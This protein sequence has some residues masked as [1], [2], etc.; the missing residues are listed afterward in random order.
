MAKKKIRKRKPSVTKKTRKANVRKRKSQAK[1]KG[2]SYIASKLH[3]YWKATYPTTKSA[4]PKAHEV[5][6]QLKEKGLKVSVANIQ[7]V[8]R[9]H[10]TPKTPDVAPFIPPEMFEQYAFYEV[11]EGEYPRWISETSK[12]IEFRS[13]ITP[14]DISVFPGGSNVEYSTHFK[15]FADYCN[16]IFKLMREKEDVPKSED[17]CL[18]ST[19]EPKKDKKGQWYVEIYTCDVH[20]EEQDYGFDNENPSLEPIEI[21]T[22][23]TELE[24]GIRK[25]PTPPPATPPTTLPTEPQKTPTTPGIEI[26]RLKSDERVAIEKIKADVSVREAKIKSIEGMFEKNKITFEQYMDAL[27]KI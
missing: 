17:A 14:K 4:L 13:R 24:T 5:L 2:V 16:N 19:T 20:G 10:R 22:P 25:L 11:I 3:K 15:D 8:V 21:I 12:D 6:S 9:K 27:S 26:E 1:Y 7:D 18:V 23:G